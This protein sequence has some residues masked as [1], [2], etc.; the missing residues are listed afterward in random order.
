VSQREGVVA[1]LKRGKMA[2]IFENKGCTEESGLKSYRE[3][4]AAVG[5]DSNR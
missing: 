5:T 4:R 2:T 3:S 1:S